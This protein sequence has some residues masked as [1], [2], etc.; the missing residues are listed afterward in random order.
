MTFGSIQFSNKLNIITMICCFL[1]GMNYL[2]LYTAFMHSNIGRY[3]GVISMTNYTG[4]ILTLCVL[5]LLSYLPK[6]RICYRHIGVV[7]LG[8][9]FLLNV[10]CIFG[11]LALQLGATYEKAYLLMICELTFCCLPPL[12]F[13]VFFN[14]SYS[15]SSHHTICYLVGM[16]FGTLLVSMF[17]MFVEMNP[18]ISYLILSCFTFITFISSVILF[19]FVPSVYNF[20]ESQK[21]ITYEDQYI[22]IDDIGRKMS[23]LHV[24]KS[25]MKEMK[26]PLVIISCFYFT[27]TFIVTRYISPIQRHYN[28]YHEPTSAGQAQQLNEKD[29]MYRYFIEIELCTFLFTL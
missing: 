14:L 5:L 27:K 1:F 17:A 4:G 6:V 20:L 15:L 29:E 10:V 21:E 22:D 11:T 3:S 16:P 25:I 24:M 13:F 8:L 9:N 2:I 19:F 12:N 18:I 26:L 23:L 28:C 7:V